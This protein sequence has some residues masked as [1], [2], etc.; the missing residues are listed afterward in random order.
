MRSKLSQILVKDGFYQV[1]LDEESSLKTTFWTPFGRYRYLRLP[2]GINLAPEEFECKLQEK[3]DGLPGVIVLRDDILVVGN[4]ETLDEANKNHDEN[5][6][7]L[8]D[9]ARQVNLRL[10]SS[11]LHLRKPEVRFMGHLI[12]SKG[13]EPDPD[14]VKA[15]EEMPELTTKQE[16]KSLL[17]FVNYLSKFL[18]K[19]SEVAQPLRDLTA[20]EAKFIWSTQ[21]AKSFKEIRELVVEH[22]VLKYYDPSEEATIQCDASEVGLGAALMQNGQ[23]VAF[24]SRTLSR[25]ERQYAQ[26]EKECLAIVFACD[27]FSQ[28]I[29]GRDKTTV[30][31]DHE[32]LEFIFQKSVLSAPC[33]L[34]RMLLRL[35]RYNIAVQ[36]KPG[37]QMNVADHLSRASLVSSEKSQDNFQVFAM[38]FESMNPLASVKVS[39]ERLTQIQT[40]TAHDPVLQVLKTTVL[41][42]WPESREETPIAIRDYWN[43]REEITLHNGILFK[44]Q[45]VIIPKAMRSEILSR[46]H[47]S[48]QG[49]ASCLRKAKDIVFWPGMNVTIK[50]MVTSCS[51][52]AEFQAKNTDQPMQTHQVPN[53][54]WSKVG[55]DL[56]TVSG[57]TFITVVDYYSDFVEIDEL[58]DTM[59]DTVIQV[60]KKQFS[61]H[62][63]P[64]TVVSDNGSQFTSQEFHEFSLEWEFNHV[65]SSPHYPK[66]NGKAESSVKVVKQLFKK[67]YRDGK[68]PWLALLDN[69][70]TPTEGLD[71]SPAQRLMSR[72]T[73][74]L[75]PT[76][77]GLLYPE[78]AQGTEEKI[79]AKREKAKYYYDRTAKKLPE[80]EIGQE[81][82]IAPLKRNH[83]WKSGTCV[84]KLSDRSYLVET[85]SFSLRRN[86]QALKPVTP[87]S[88]MHVEHP[89]SLRS[90]SQAERPEISSDAA[91]ESSSPSENVVADSS[92]EVQT[93]RTRCGR[94]IKPPLRFRDSGY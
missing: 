70:N 23:P 2:F 36:Y 14:K 61:R 13:L 24:A 62:G 63:I 59:S 27:K 33:R 20:K 3:L 19:L 16:L 6:V 69:R 86:R 41:T 89:D 21:H 38:E 81:V 78:V 43:Y 9:R 18:P 37:P 4:G 51:V 91:P 11:K 56:F 44:N 39:P 46:V 25:T 8:L 49:I 76:A 77:S 52:C 30:E 64:D 34:Q 7:R 92:T 82:R 88:A 87:P 45:R 22:P 53:R 67:A 68:D 65:T 10:N 85:G 31:S 72:R 94:T 35:Q 79:K 84:E 50:E 15:V 5:L 55:T 71:T 73:R 80:L 26:I 75:L 83:P 93:P 29:A 66:S 32:P 28:Y 40:S 48:H 1:G 47:S 90:E 74:T 57:K 42:G 58:S 60:L 17:G 12:T 54:P